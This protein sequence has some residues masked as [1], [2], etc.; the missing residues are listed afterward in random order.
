MN[1]KPLVIEQG[2]FK[3]KTTN[4]T[5]IVYV[6]DMIV[7]GP[8]ID[9]INQIYKNLEKLD[10]Q[11]TNL[12]EISYF[13]GMEIY[14]DR[15]QKSI[16]INQKKYLNELLEKFGKKHLNPVSTP[17]EPGIKLTKSEN[18]ASDSERFRYQQEV[19]SLIYLSIKTRPDIA[20]AVNNCA[21]FMSNPN[22]SHFTAVN[23]IWKYL[24]YRPNLGLFYIAEQSPATSPYV[25]GYVDAD[26]GGDIL[27]RKSTTGY[28]FTFSKAPISW[29][30]K[31]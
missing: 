8:K 19:G 28:Y 17:S 12:G 29:S 1:F 18:E 22:K 6:D 11:L 21:R 15:K 31:L 2:V 4:I 9:E 26:W 27:T 25:L 13:L 30:S 24:N 10:I 7:I 20:Y 14:R 3:N 5:I 23:R 16:T